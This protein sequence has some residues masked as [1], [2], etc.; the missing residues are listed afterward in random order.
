MWHWLIILLC[1]GSDGI[2]TVGRGVVTIVI[3]NLRQMQRAAFGGSLHFAADAVL[4]LQESLVRI[5]L[6]GQS[7]CR[8]DLDIRSGTK[9]RHQLRGRSVKWAGVGEQIVQFTE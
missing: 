7:V 9:L 2:G 5:E 8:L 1:D 3:R 4:K 6:P